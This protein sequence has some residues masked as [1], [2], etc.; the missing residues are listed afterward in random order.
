MG[1]NVAVRVAAVD[2]GTNS[3]RL[4]VAERDAHTGAVVELARRSRIVRLGQGVGRTGRFAPEALERT[5]AA[6][7]E[8]A[9]VIEELKAESVAF[10]ATSATRDVADR[11]EFFSG[12]Q[13]ILGVR[14]EVISGDEEAGLS[15]AGAVGSLSTGPGPWLVIDIGGGSTECVVGASARSA[16]ESGGTTSGALDVHASVSLDIGSVRLTERHLADSEGS[17]DRASP[18]GIAAVRRDVEAALGGAAARLPLA[19]RPTL[20]GVG[21]S[22]TTL[23]AVRRGSKDGVHGVRLDIDEVREVSRLLLSADRAQRAAIDV[24]EPGRVD[25]IP[26]G[27]LILLTAMERLGFPEIVVSRH[28]LLDGLAH[29]LVG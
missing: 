10:V 1:R 26:A 23:A 15:F 28:G 25:V 21:G 18:E 24:I 27:S 12:V 13:R 29:R 7:A 19:P 5:F 8:F 11:A 16:P 4:L 17:L 14:P 22:V 9:Q 3:I 20:V 6:C 2:C